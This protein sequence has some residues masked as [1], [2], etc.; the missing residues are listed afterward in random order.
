MAKQLIIITGASDGIGAAAAKQLVELGEKVVVVG[1]SPEKTKAVAEKLNCDYFVADFTDLG[2]VRDLASKLISK[3][4]KID[5]LVNNAGGIYGKREVTKDG[6]EKGFQINHLAPFLLT[7]LLLPTLQ[8][9]HAKVIQT[10][11]FAA[12]RYSKFDIND[13]QTEKNYSPMRVYGNGKLENILFTRELDRRYRDKGIAAAAF[14]PGVVG[15]NFAND[16]YPWI[17]FLY[18]TPIVNKLLTISPD[19]GAAGLIW[20]SETEPAK[21]W[22]PGEYYEK[23]KIAK[24]SPE[25]DDASLAKELWDK[26][27]KLLK[28]T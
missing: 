8:A 11:S 19:K 14:H 22:L 9:S 18:H 24:S 4:P 26:S 13:L 16:T 17:R 25:A 23:N 5:V 20:L 6:F 27:E 12:K 2:Q 1:R 28:Q 3:Y 7:K 15:T 10:S 21:D